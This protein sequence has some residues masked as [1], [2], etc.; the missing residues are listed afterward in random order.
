MTPRIPP[1]E[2]EELEVD[3]ASSVEE[4]DEV[5]RSSDCDDILL[6]L[7]VK[8]VV[9]PSTVDDDDAAANTKA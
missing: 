5:C 7:P 9:K 2:D 8:E 6:L 4:S 1:L 3:G